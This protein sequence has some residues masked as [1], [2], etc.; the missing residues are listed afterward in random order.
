MSLATFALQQVEAKLPKVI[1][2]TTH[3]I[4][5][6][7][8]AAFF[9]GLAV[10]CW[11]SDKRAA[12][13]AAGTS[14]LVLVE[15][16]LTD[17]KPGVKRILPFSV[18]GRIDGSLAAISMAIPRTFGFENTKQARIFKINAFVVATVVGLTDWNDERAR[19]KQS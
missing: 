4:I 17:Y 7:C 14:A 1:S 8:H 5:D 11:K 13:A 10:I 3:G 18:H 19:A 2:P 12:V 15:G 16:L 6:Y 9:A